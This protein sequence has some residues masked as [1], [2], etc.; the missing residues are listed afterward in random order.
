MI[1]QKKIPWKTIGTVSIFITSI[2]AIFYSSSLNENLKGELYETEFA[3]MIEEFNDSSN[4]KIHL[5]NWNFYYNFEKNLGQIS[6]DLDKKEWKISNIMIYLPK[7]ISCNTVNVSASSELHGKMLTINSK[8]ETIKPKPECKNNTIYISE[9]DRTFME[10]KIIIKYSLIDFKPKGKFTFIE[11][12]YNSLQSGESGNVQ[13][14]LGNKYQCN[15]SCIEILKF[16]EESPRGFD[17]DIRIDFLMPKG[18]PRYSSFKINTFS[19][20]ILFFRNLLLG[21]GIALFISTVGKSIIIILK[22]IKKSTINILKLI[23]KLNNWINI[24]LFN[25]A[26]NILACRKIIT[27]KLTERI[28]IKQ[29]YP[30]KKPHPPTTPTL[31][32]S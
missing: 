30:N 25:M 21:L 5:Q 32:G 1:F 16:A 24:T 10:E 23:K 26:N 2:I 7:N 4:N 14:I 18:N 8:G 11:N 9:F 6:F 29:P 19:R 22:L 13:F 28:K 3:I 17:T 15:P 31:H 27:T 12:G 20:N